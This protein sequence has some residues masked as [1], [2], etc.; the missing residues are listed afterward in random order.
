MSLQK[1]THAPSRVV[2][3]CGN[4]GGPMTLQKT[5]DQWPLEA[6]NWQPTEVGPRVELRNSSS[7]R[8]GPAQKRRRWAADWPTSPA[9]RWPLAEHRRPPKPLDSPSPPR[10][11]S[12]SG[13]ARSRPGL[14]GGHRRGRERGPEAGAGSAA[15]GSG[16]Q[17]CGETEGGGE[18]ICGLLRRVNEFSAT[19]R[20]DGLSGCLAPFPRPRSCIAA[21][22]AVPRIERRRQRT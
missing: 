11:S 15:E 1:T 20:L 4:G 7:T 18:G 16:A 12:S 21:S 5:P 9:T 8:W 3:S 10:R 14:C 13:F 19:A 2:P 6:A 17:D 22:R